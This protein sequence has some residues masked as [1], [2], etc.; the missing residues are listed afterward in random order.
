MG[1]NTED[2]DSL[3]ATVGIDDTVGIQ[4][5]GIVPV[6]IGLNSRMKE[7]ILNLQQSVT[8]ILK[9]LKV[10][11]NNVWVQQA[12][13]VDTMTEKMRATDDEITILKYFRAKRIS[14]REHVSIT[15]MYF[16]GDAKLWWHTSQNAGDSDDA[17][18]SKVNPLQL[19]TTISTEKQ[20][21]CYNDLIY[22]TAKVNGKDVRAILDTFVTNNFVARREADMLGLNLLGSTSQIKAVNIG[23]IP[24]HGVAE[25]IL[26]VGSW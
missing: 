4:P 3:M 22:V 6:F 23:A 16:N 18:P 12:F 5:R 2:T 26:N 8:D 13:V 9:D 15:S 14:E 17:G 19:F 24:M 20:P 21:S 1:L 10:R 11:F 7:R 25:T